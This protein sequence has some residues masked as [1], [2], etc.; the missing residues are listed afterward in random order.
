MFDSRTWPRRGVL[1]DPDS[2]LERRSNFETGCLLF[3]GP[4]L[5]AWSWLGDLILLVPRLFHS[6]THPSNMQF[7]VVPVAH[8]S[9]IR[10]SGGVLEMLALASMSKK[11]HVL[12]HGVLQ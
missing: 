10:T 5:Q 1:E 8:V 9:T 6:F 3:P 7:A 11:N 4:L 2:F 12:L